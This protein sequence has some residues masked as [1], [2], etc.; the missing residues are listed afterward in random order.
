M[1]TTTIHLP[2]AVQDELSAVARRTGRSEAEIIVEAVEH[3]LREAHRPRPK[4]VGIYDDPEVTGE[5]YEEW[6]AANWSPDR[7]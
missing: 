2:Q 7:E 1:A 6:L 5:N 3:H 4:A